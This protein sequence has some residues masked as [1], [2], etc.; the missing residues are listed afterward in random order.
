MANSKSN[1]NHVVKNLAFMLE[2]KL[3]NG[4]AVTYLVTAEQINDCDGHFVQLDGYVYAKPYRY[5][6][7]W[8]WG[9]KNGALIR[10]KP[11]EGEKKGKGRAWIR[12]W[13]NKTAG[14]EIAKA[15]EEAFGGKR[16]LLTPE[17]VAEMRGF[18][19]KTA[20]RPVSAVQPKPQAVV[21]SAP[22]D[23]D[24]P[25]EKTENANV[26]AGP[27]RPQPEIELP[28]VAED[29]LAIGDSEENLLDR[30]QAGDPK[31]FMELGATP[32]HAVQWAR[33]IRS[34]EAVING[35]EDVVLI[36]G[37]GAKTASKLIS[38]WHAK[39]EK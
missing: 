33:Q 6:Q 12:N 24:V 1:R 3:Q 23:T 17:D 30:L 21:A 11:E 34:G 10:E 7:R 38:N 14:Y 18:A 22:S 19:K 26:L 28:P 31:L 39:F 37:V 29:D 16:Q 5:G 9:R 35:I 32:G 25:P 15:V 13:W 20:T 27:E 2:S 36:R 8:I 4:A